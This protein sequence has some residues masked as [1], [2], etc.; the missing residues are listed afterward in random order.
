MVKIL[1]VKPA[2]N[3]HFFRKNYFI[4]CFSQKNTLSND[5]SLSVSLLPFP[6][7]TLNRNLG[8][9]IQLRKM[10]SSCDWECVICREEGQKNCF[11]C[12]EQVYSLEF[13][14]MQDYLLMCLSISVACNLFSEVPVLYFLWHQFLVG[15]RVGFSVKSCASRLIWRCTTE[16]IKMKNNKKNQ[17]WIVKVPK[18]C[19]KNLNRLQTKCMTKT[20]HIQSVF[21]C[22]LSWEHL[23][24]CRSM[25]FLASFQIISLYV[26][27]TASYTFPTKNTSQNGFHN[28]LPSFLTP[29]DFGLWMVI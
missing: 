29:T 16:V 27:V 18:N 12:L 28:Y 24:I 4:G 9:L 15:H 10:L 13:E 6:T 23:F 25:S 2:N 1:Y 5:L 22:N 3:W 26:K 14:A 20:T 11:C 8:K 7:H 19:L 21:L 17:Y